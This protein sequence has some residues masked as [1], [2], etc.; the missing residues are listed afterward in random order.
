VRLS[1]GRAFLVSPSI[2]YPG[3]LVPICLGAHLSTKISVQLGAG[4]VYAV[5]APDAAVGPAPQKHPKQAISHCHNSLHKDL[6][7]GCVVYIMDAAAAGRTSAP[8]YILTSGSTAAAPDMA[9]GPHARGGLA[10]NDWQSL[11]LAPA[12]ASTS[13]AG[14]AAHSVAAATS[15]A[16]L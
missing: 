4:C 5:F 2:Q 10:W 14:A 3:C 7:T 9:C 13:R 8:A 16:V 11:H 1:Q 12:H 15:P 6:S